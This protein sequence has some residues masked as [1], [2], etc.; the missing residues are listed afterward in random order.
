MGET[1]WR[2]HPTGVG[3]KPESKLPLPSAG[4]IEAGIAEAVLIPVPS[5]C[6]LAKTPR[7]IRSCEVSLAKRAEVRNLINKCS[8]RYRS[9]VV[10]DD[11]RTASNP[12]E[13]RVTDAISQ[14][15]CIVIDL[16]LPLAP[17]P[18]ARLCTVIGP[19]RVCIS[20]VAIHHTAAHPAIISPL[21]GAD[22]LIIHE[23]I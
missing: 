22:S 13:G 1:A 15:E 19:E 18:P 6:P 11:T 20:V 23:G 17:P 14:R 7:S 2:G 3:S 9:R 8:S 16:E 21:I 10:V 4:L 5:V 12:N